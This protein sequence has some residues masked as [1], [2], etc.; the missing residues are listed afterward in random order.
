MMQGLT[1]FLLNIGLNKMEWIP[2]DLADEN[3]AG[4]GDVIVC[5]K[6][7]SVALYGAASVRALKR[8][9]VEEGDD[10]VFTHWMPLPEAPTNY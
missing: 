5:R 8:A 7:R 4:F 9:A 6:N 2:I 1:L 3:P 10:C